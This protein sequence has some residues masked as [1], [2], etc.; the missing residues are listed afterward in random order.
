M[1]KENEIKLLNYILKS[2][3]NIAPTVLNVNLPLESSKSIPVIF[4]NEQNNQISP[5]PPKFIV[6]DNDLFNFEK[7]YQDSLKT[8]TQRIFFTLEII[9]KKTEDKI[10]IDFLGLELKE[11]PI[12]LIASKNILEPKMFFE[13]SMSAIMEINKRG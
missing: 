4:F 6:L 2:Q 9:D 8:N 13:I 11:F 5:A 10:K 7:L 1:K 3:K 12:I